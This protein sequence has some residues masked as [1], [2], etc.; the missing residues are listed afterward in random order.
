MLGSPTHELLTVY[1]PSSRKMQDHQTAAR[2]I[3]GR[4]SGSKQ[5]VAWLHLPARQVS[6]TVLDQALLGIANF[7]T[8][9]LLARWLS[10][11][12]Y[13]AYTVATAAFWTILPPYGGLLAEPILI[14]G[15]VRFRDQLASYFTVLT[16]FHCCF[17]AFIAFG[18]AAAG[19]CLVFS[20]SEV[21]GFGLLGYAL[22]APVLPMLPL[23]RNTLYAQSAP[24]RAAG[25]AAVY[26]AGTLVILYLLYTSGTLSPFTAPLAAAG[27]TAVATACVFAARRPELSSLWQGRDFARCVASA[28][29]RYGRWAS[30]TQAVEAFPSTFFYLLIPLLA[31]LEANAAVRVL[32]VLIMPAIQAILAFR[33]LLVP[34]LRRMREQG[35]I[36]SIIWRALIVLVAGAALYALLIAEFGGPLM[37]LLYR[38]RY[39]EYARF[40]WLTGLIPVPF[41]AMEVLGSFLRARERPDRILW[42]NMISAVV[43]VVF[44]GAAVAAW[45]LLGALLGLLGAYVTTMLVMA[46]WVIGWSR[47]RRPIDSTHP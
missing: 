42:A 6:W 35:Y 22:A 29:W 10:P 26:L 30:V 3:P 27:A 24:R 19:V 40:A 37:D 34:A 18:F 43:T 41:A 7:A 46:W 14:F 2:E 32:I 11:A 33:L 36:P 31:G 28:H 16:L 23:L 5:P 17:S 1:F 21:S 4:S 15:A 38:G 13:G 9:L 12:D 44:G 25:V 20:G 39:G 45:G 8:T 47:R